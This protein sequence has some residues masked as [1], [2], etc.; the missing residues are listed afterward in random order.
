MPF[1]KSAEITIKNE[2]DKPQEIS[3]IVDHAPV[4]S[5][6]DNLGYFHAKWHRDLESNPK[7]PID[8]KIMEAKGSG[9]FVGVALHVWN[10]KG[11]WWGEGDEKFFVDGEKFPSTIGTGSE[12]YFGYAW[13]DPEVFVKAFHSQPTNKNNRGQ[14]SVSRWHIGGNIPFRTS[15][16]A[17]IEKYFPN[18]RETFYDCV[19]YWYL[20]KNG[21]DKIQKTPLKDRLGYYTGFEEYKEKNALEGEKLP[22]RTI[23][24]GKLRSQNFATFGN[25]W[26]DEAQIWWTDAGIGDFVEFGIS[27]A[28]KTTTN[29]FAQFTKANDYAIIQNYF[30]GK[31]IGKPIDGYSPNITTTG[32]IDLGKVKLKKGGNIFK[33]EIIGVNPKA[34]KS[35]MVGLDYLKF[36]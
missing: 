21:V 27:S 13:C 5:S 6:F 9:R 28:K 18:S 3:L 1:E 20:S 11:G 17:D 31:K 12:D 25:K 16:E 14:V 15:F 2:S 10:A 36:E 7:R 26:S 22:V 29:L 23:S 35:Y 30:N 34:K 4:K 33:I 8:W 32:K 24:N 19:A